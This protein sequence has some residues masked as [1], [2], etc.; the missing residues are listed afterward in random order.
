MFAYSIYFRPL[1]RPI[2][3]VLIP[4]MIGI[5]VREYAK[6]Y[7]KVNLLFKGV[8]AFV[9]WIILP[10]LVF[11]SV[12]IRRP[13]AIYAFGSPAALALIGLS[14]T[15][16][17]AAI[18][19]YIMRTGKEKSI[20][21]LLN[22]SFMN[23]TFLGLA[24]VYVVTGI[25]GVG[26]ASIYAVTMGIL[27]LTL[28]VMLSAS[29]SESKPSFKLILLGIITFPAAFALIVAL[30]FIGFDVGWPIQIQAW[31]DTFADL[32]VPIMLLAA[33]YHIPLVN[34]RRYLSTISLVGIIRLLIC[35]LVTYGAII[36]LGV[37]ETIAGATLLLSA[38][39]PGVYN[40]ILAENF[41]LNKELYGS[42]VFYLTLISLFI[43]VPIIV[44]FFMGIKL[45]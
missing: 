39:P 27:H 28:G 6:G 31:V 7:Y 18:L 2:L 17:I 37:G 13:D 29:S 12:A 35:P 41:N 33:G 21:I 24:I 11:G 16:A 15:S 42:I 19:T 38:M 10:A 23:Y 1:I 36:I 20:A 40:I 22:A 34:P 43:S 4:L 44:R 45:F 3:L 8:Y 32:S 30:L 14:A 9:L 25:Q 26:V 5:L